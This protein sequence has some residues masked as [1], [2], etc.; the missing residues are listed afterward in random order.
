M[1]IRSC[2]AG[3]VISCALAVSL[4]ADSITL[5][6]SSL[7][8]TQGWAFYNGGGPLTESQVFSVSGGLLHQD[9]IGGGA[10]GYYY[11]QLGVVASGAFV[12]DWDAR[13]VNEENSGYFDN[14]N[15]AGF[16]FEADTGS[17][18]Y[19][20]GLSL[21]GISLYDEGN[22]AHGLQISAATLAAGGISLTDFHDYRLAADPVTGTWD[23]YID[24]TFWAVGQGLIS[25]SLNDLA[26]G[27]LTDGPNAEG[28]IA[29]FSYSYEAG[30]SVPEPA[31][32]GLLGAS[33]AAVFTRR[34][35]SRARP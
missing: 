32:I 11:R 17:L 22:P 4:H 10:N 19:L 28:D 33:L 23:L 16:A 12:L 18:S 25:S 5:S 1:R 13:L 6:T 9:S 35:K 20:M 21:N 3:L 15:A 14:G 29:A 26:L 7:P 8:S 30:T 2:I 34:R 31:T 24:G 27:D